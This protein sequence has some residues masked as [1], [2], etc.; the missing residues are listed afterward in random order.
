M[1]VAAPQ[2]AMQPRRRFGGTDELAQPR[3][4]ALETTSQRER[5]ALRRKGEREL[6]FE[7]LGAIKF[8]PRGVRMIGLRKSPDEVWLVQSEARGTAS[9]QCGQTA[10]EYLIELISAT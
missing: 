8:G 6:R 1:H 2:I 3:E 9:V 5:R 7:A 10:T 4:Q